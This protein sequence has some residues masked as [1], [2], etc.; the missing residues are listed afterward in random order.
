MKK[1]LSV[2]VC[3]VILSFTFTF[4]SAATAE[5]T[6]NE[7]ESLIRQLTDFKYTA[8]GSNIEEITGNPVTDKA[9][10]KELREKTGI[11]ESNDGIKF[12]EINGEQGKASF[13]FEHLKSFLTDE[14]VNENIELRHALIQVGENVYT[15]TSVAYAIAP[16]YPDVKYGKT[17]KECI[18]FVDGDTVIF[19]ANYGYEDTRRQI[20][21][22]YTENGWR[23]SGG[24]GAKSFLSYTWKNNNAENPETGDIVIPTLVC[25]IISTL[26]MCVTFGKRKLPR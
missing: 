11:D 19:E 2:I 25:I 7:A 21:F 15:P 22:E 24:D 18:T 10:I 14:Y 9:V 1:I 5:L 13:W 20:D 4:T 17:I 23:I 12:Y 8:L 3:F 26:G 16:S 6:L